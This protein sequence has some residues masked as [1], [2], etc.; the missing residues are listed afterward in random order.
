VC[1]NF[2]LPCCS[3]KS[4]THSDSGHSSTLVSADLLLGWKEELEEDVGFKK[5]TLISPSLNFLL[6]EGSTF[7]VE[8]NHSFFLDR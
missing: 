3:T 7:W 8:D 2:V 6:M 1:G 5:G 4:Y